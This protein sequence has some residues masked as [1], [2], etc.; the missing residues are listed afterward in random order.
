MK[1]NP[2]KRNIEILRRFSKQAKVLGDARFDQLNDFG[3]KFSFGTGKASRI[4]AHLPDN[5][6]Q[7]SF[8]M[9]LRFFIL[10]DKNEYQFKK[11]CDLLIAEGYQSDKVLEWKKAYENIFNQEVIGLQIDKKGLTTKMVFHTILNEENFHQEIEQKGMLQIQS[12]PIIE[13][14]ARTKF[15]GVVSALRDCIIA[16][17]KQ[18]IEDYLKIYDN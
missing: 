4:E 13:S 5:D 15:L 3:L 7:R 10:K 9:D 8:L 14:L 11:V 12:N 1:T 6:I 2:S 18:I 16:F 17:D